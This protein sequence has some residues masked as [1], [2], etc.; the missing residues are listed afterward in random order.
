[1]KQSFNQFLLLLSVVGLISSCRETSRLPAP[2]L[3]GT[4]P[5]IAPQ[6]SADPDKNHYDYARTRS[7][8]NALASLANPTRPVFEF[9]FDL[10]NTRDKKVKAVEVYKSLLTGATSFN[11]TVFNG[12]AFG[13]R[14]LVG[15]YTSFPVSVSLDSEAAIAGLQRVLP[16]PQVPA[17]PAPNVPYLLTVKAPTDIQ[18]NL[19]SLK[20][21][22][23]AIVF[24]FEYI[25]EDNTR[26]IL[27]PVTK[28]SV[29][30]V[31]GG[32]TAKTVDVLVTTTQVNSPFAAVA[33]IRD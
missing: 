32:M 24:T 26:V 13:T 15:T 27:T 23:D 1:M 29:V 14:V 6:L 19:L 4:V 3:S 17:A 7:S 21:G 22:S 18:P 5:L 31:I 28:T 16:Q 20:R 2:Q 30:D 25:L 8:K 9:T 12:G 10:D 33:I 11:G